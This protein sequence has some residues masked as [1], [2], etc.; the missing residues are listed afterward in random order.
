MCYL[1]VL[2]KKTKGY[3]QGEISSFGAMAKT[4]W[5]ENSAQ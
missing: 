2:G 3:Y 5:S 1:A 4:Y